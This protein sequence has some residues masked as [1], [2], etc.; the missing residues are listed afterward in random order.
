MPICRRESELQEVF[1][2]KGIDVSRWQEKIDWEKVKADGI[3]FAF[4]KASQGGSISSLKIKPFTDSYFKRNITNA[5]AAGVFCGVYHYLTG[6]NQEDVIAEAEYL[7]R[8]LA[9]YK[10][11]I[12]YPVALDFEDF[13][14]TAHHKSL[15]SVLIRLFT[16]IIREAGYTPILYANRS[17]LRKHI[18]LSSL[19]N[20]DI[21]YALYYT[22]R[23]RI[24]P[25]SDFSKMTVWQWSNSGSVNGIRGKVDMNV[26]FYNYADDTKK[27]P[28]KDNAEQQKTLFTV[29]DVVEIKNSAQRYY[30]NGSAIPKWVKE[31]YDHII[32]KTLYYGKKVYKSGSECVLLGKKINRKTDRTIAGINTWIAVENIKKTAIISS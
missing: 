24:N 8:V 22:P 7:V 5:D 12:K 25:P 32:T 17:F 28:V 18:D 16:G 31:D 4:I 14:Y 26:G 15:N 23:R 3:E 30:E 20:L 9:P 13:R 11:I 21:W 29:G 19:S 6:V 27:E 10:N 1:Y 2:L